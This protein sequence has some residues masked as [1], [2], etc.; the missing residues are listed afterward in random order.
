MPTLSFEKF[1]I[2]TSSEISPEFHYGFLGQ[3]SQKSFDD[4]ILTV[5]GLPTQLRTTLERAQEKNSQLQA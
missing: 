1:E 5:L 3:V 2:L 4:G